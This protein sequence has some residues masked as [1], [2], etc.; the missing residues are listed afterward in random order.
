MK[1]DLWTIGFILLIIGIGIPVSYGIYEIILAE[2]EWY[3]S[4]SITLIAFGLIFLL[5][6]AVKERTESSKPEE[7]V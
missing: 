1:V 6:S 2:M 4:V 5:I 7:K 3:W